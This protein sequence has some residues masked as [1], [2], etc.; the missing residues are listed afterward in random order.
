[1]ILVEVIIANKLIIFKIID[2]QII[3]QNIKSG[4]APQQDLQFTREQLL[5]VKRVQ[6]ERH[7]AEKLRQMGVKVKGNMGVRYED[8]KQ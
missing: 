5:D 2:E 7:A 3:K 8:S 1:M 4:K 6:Q